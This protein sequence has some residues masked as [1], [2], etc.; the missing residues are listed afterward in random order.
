MTHVLVLLLFVLADEDQKYVQVIFIMASY[1]GIILHKW[2]YFE[3]EG[4][5]CVLLEVEP[6]QLV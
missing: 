1:F 4:N 5:F 2:F 3:P 6:F